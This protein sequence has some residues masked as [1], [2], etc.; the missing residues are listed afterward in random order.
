MEPQEHRELEVI[1]RQPTL[2]YLVLRYLFIDCSASAPRLLSF[3]GD[4]SPLTTLHLQR[5]QVPTG[6]I[7]SLLSM[8][9]TLRTVT[10]D[11]MWFEEDGT[12]TK[13]IL[14][15]LRPSRHTLRHLRAPGIDQIHDHLPVSL[16]PFVVLESLVIPATAFIGESEINLP[17]QL[18][19][20]PL[21][22]YSFPQSLRRLRLT[23]SGNFWHTPKIRN[24]FLEQLVKVM[25]NNS[26]QK[27][28]EL[29]IQGNSS[30]L[31]DGF[32]KPYD[33]EEAP[34]DII[35]RF[36]ALGT[37]LRCVEGWC[38]SNFDCETF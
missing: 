22:T 17:A 38:D 6:D 3:T 35:T 24:D 23:S 9:S 33:Y 37:S 19:R 27:L 12:E 8:F 14:D 36:R 16:T 21:T 2:R 30:L 11:D 26:Q 15:A 29:H 4:H 1:L 7:T 32:W 31:V 5:G 20:V 10:L 34:E 13:R 25:G 28:E 18:A